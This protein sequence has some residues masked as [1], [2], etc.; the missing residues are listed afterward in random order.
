MSIR[1]MGTGSV[2]ISGR[3][4]TKM[5]VKGDVKLN[6]VEKIKAFFGGKV[7]VEVSDA[8]GYL[9]ACYEKGK[10]E[11]VSQSLLENLCITDRRVAVVDDDDGDGDVGVDKHFPIGSKE[12]DVHRA[13]N[14]SLNYQQYAVAYHGASEYIDNDGEADKS[15][16]SFSKDLVKQINSHIFS[17]NYDESSIDDFV[18][19]LVS[20]KQLCV[21][22]EYLDCTKSAYWNVPDEWKDSFSRL[23]AQVSEKLKGLEIPSLE[24]AE[25]TNSNEE[26][27]F[28]IRGLFSYDFF[29]GR[30][31]MGDTDKN[32]RSFIESVEDAAQL[33]MIESI[34]SGQ[35]LRVFLGRY[36]SHFM[37]DKNSFEDGD[38]YFSLIETVRERLRNE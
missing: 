31:Y 7:C 8:E 33:G 28:Q 12:R 21:A 22:K 14:I 4:A 18:E 36:D 9:K 25:G 27:Y 1:D 24:N 3:D 16:D 15:I 19:G 30:E 13:Q 6:F 2:M 23:Y 20:A 26:L 10:I 5:A 11:N 34:F 37:L 29:I 38:D 17:D 35:E 32:I